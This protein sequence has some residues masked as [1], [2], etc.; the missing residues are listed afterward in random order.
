MNRVISARCHR[1]C[2][3]LAVADRGVTRRT[4]RATGT[5]A[6]RNGIGLSRECRRDRASRGNGVGSIGIAVKRAA[7][8]AAHRG[9]LV[10]GIGR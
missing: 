4:D 8:G 9:D 7:A 6:G 1:V 2:L 10:V 5:G 3:G